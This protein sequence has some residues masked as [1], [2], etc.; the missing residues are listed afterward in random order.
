MSIPLLILLLACDPKPTVSPDD[1]GSP[2]DS[3]PGE[4][5]PVLDLSLS[6]APVFDPILGGPVAVEASAAGS[7]SMELVVLDADGGL[8]ATITDAW[9]GRDATGAWA[10]AGRYTVQLTATLG[11]QQEE[12]SAE[13]RVVRCGALAAWAEGDGGTSATHVPLYWHMSRTVQGPAEAFTQATS[14]EDEL[15]NP[16]SLPSPGDE[17][18]L[19]PE[20]EALPVAF[21]WDSQPILTLEL[22]DSTVLGSSGLPGAGVS[23]E[24]PGWTAISGADSLDPSVPVVFQAAEPLGAGPGVLEETLELR[25]VR[26]DGSQRWEIGSQQLPVRWYLLLDEPTFQR[27]EDVYNAWVAAID[28]ALRAIDGVAPSDEAVIDALVSWIYDD[29]GLSYDTR[30]GA[31]Y[32]TAYVGN[33]T[34]ATFDM[35]GFLRPGAG[36]TVNCS[37]C[38]SI[39]SAWANMLGAE[40]VYSIVLQNFDLNYILAIGGDAFTHCP[41]G[42]WGCSFSYHAVNTNDGGATIW[43]AT[44]ALDGDENPSAPPSE[45]LMVQ[46]IDADEYLDRLVMQGRASINYEGE[47]LLQ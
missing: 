33:W 4:S 20:G 1:T 11:E 44:L 23:L 36:R 26:D 15:D 41:F 43:D 34:P 30:Y 10:P 38:A 13:L 18:E 28:P 47:T 31:S 3:T 27:P 7:D 25:F 19:F 40:L 39:L 22:G 42:S 21:T 16:V 2:G 29:L 9:D 45:V 17:L 46:H 12:A 24:I 8:V 6:A 37:D 35:T 32:F 5:E 14:L